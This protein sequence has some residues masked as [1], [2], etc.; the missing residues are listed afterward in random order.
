MAVGNDVQFQRFCTVLDLTE[1]ARDPRF[2]TNQDRVAHRDVLVALLATAIGT[3]QRAPLLQAL[4]EQAIPAGPVNSIAEVFADPQVIARRMRIDLSAPQLA[5]GQIPS[6]RT[7][8]VFSAA[9]LALQRP[10][11]QLGEPTA[12]VLRELAPP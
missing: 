5:G 10:A 4:E 2:A 8:I 6:I 12:E 11:Q 9:Q 3:W 1:T 7:P